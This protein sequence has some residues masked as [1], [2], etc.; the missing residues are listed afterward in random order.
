M[1]SVLK[2]TC[3]PLHLLLLL[4]IKTFR[5]SGTFFTKTDI[6]Y[7]E[8][9][10]HTILIHLTTSRYLSV[11]CRIPVFKPGSVAIF[12]RL[13]TQ[14]G[15]LQDQINISVPASF[16]LAHAF[17]AKIGFPEQ[18]KGTSAAIESTTVSEVC[19]CLGVPWLH[20]HYVCVITLTLTA[21]RYCRVTR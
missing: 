2:K 19:Q 16:W 7:H 17:L 5:A 15:V 3:K 10:L 20:S 13:L 12:L 21:R 4:C 14:C 1:Q 18:K 11:F 9:R 6:C 8:A